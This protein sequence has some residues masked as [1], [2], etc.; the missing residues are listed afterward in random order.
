MKDLL[1]LTQWLS[2]AFPTGAYAYSH[3]LEA[4]ISGDLSG[5]EAAQAWI[6]DVLTCGGGLSDAV[7]IAQILGGA[8]P[9][10]MADYARALAGSKERLSETLEQGAA[11]SRALGAL[12]VS[13]TEAPLPV[14]FGAAARGLSL[15]PE[16]IISLYLHSFAANLASCATRFMPLGQS[17]GQRL[18]AALHPSI[19][20]TAKR[21]LITPLDH[22][23]TCACGAEIAAMAHETL[24]VRIYNT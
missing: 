20:A 24:D 4:A 12:G 21:A 22:L 17:A 13:A 15:P 10:L 18:L 6:A 9:A 11:F 19:E 1:T 2:P 7:L 8:E 16:Q 3:G 14:A 5:A 23:T